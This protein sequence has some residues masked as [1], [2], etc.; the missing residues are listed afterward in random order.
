MTLY[1]TTCI[2]GTRCIPL[3]RSILLL[4]TGMHVRA[5]FGSCENFDNLVAKHFIDKY[6]CC[7]IPTIHITIQIKL[8]TFPP[9]PEMQ[10]SIARYVSAERLEG[11]PLGVPE[12]LRLHPLDLRAR[13]R[14]WPGGEEEEVHPA[15]QQIRWNV[16]NTILS[17]LISHRGPKT[18][19]PFIR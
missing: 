12:A 19:L 16:Q 8:S 4:T 2:P 13:P 14:P 10:R 6:Q 17:H 18:V 11:V 15:L 3:S 9:L 5:I 1:Y 7:T